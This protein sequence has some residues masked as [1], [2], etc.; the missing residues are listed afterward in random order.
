MNRTLSLPKAAELLTEVL[1]TTF[2]GLMSRCTT[3]F[4]CRY[5]TALRTCLKT[6]AAVFSEYRLSCI[7]QSCSGHM[8]HTYSVL[9]IADTRNS[10]GIHLQC[11]S[12]LETSVSCK[13]AH[14]GEVIEQ[15]AS[16]QVL[17]HEHPLV[18]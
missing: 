7:Q 4:S 3:L 18:R 12:L 10:H 14:L 15:H 9:H 17:K 2:S 6:A 8:S 16:L 5:A 13:V 11:C 1:N